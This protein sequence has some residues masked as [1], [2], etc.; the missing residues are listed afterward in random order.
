MPIM[1]GDTDIGRLCKKAEGKELT[2]ECFQQNHLNFATDTTEIRYTKSNQSV[3][4]NATTTSEGTFPGGSQWRRNPV[5]MCN[6]DQGT[7][8]VSSSG[9]ALLGGKGGNADQTQAY[10]NAYGIHDERCPTGVQFEPLFEQGY[11]W[12]WPVA[13]HPRLHHGRQPTAAGTG[14]RRVLTQLE[15]GLRRD[16]TSVECLL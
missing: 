14:G 6:C 11:V 15:V 3:F 13:T 10:P 2:E 8:C 12:Y 4:I 16:A 9:R 1:A 5:P 7:N